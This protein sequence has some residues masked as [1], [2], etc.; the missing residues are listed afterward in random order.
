MRL[1]V[2]IGSQ[3][4]SGMTRRHV[5]IVSLKS[6]RLDGQVLIGSNLGIQMNPHRKAA[7]MSVNEPDHEAET[8]SPP[9]A[10]IK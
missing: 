7:V 4:A 8:M 6:Y 1:S 2:Y 3:R 10:A 5:H 9:P